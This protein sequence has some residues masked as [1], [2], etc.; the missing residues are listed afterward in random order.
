MGRSGDPNLIFFRPSTDPGD[1]TLSVCSILVGPRGCP[2]Y[3]PQAFR[4]LLAG[5]GSRRGLNWLYKFPVGLW[6][7]STQAILWKHTSFFKAYK[8]APASVAVASGF[9]SASWRYTADQ[10]MQR[11]TEEF[12]APTR[13]SQ[14]FALWVSARGGMDA[15]SPRMRCPNSKTFK[16]LPC[17]VGQ[18]GPQVTYTTVEIGW[19]TMFWECSSWR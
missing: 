11:G 16:P 19:N 13:R 3:L 1:W 18:N 4:H 10:A 12:V 8:G 5:P 9:D 2:P 15:C 7:S 14:L 6:A 17:W